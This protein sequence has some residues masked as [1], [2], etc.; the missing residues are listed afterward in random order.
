MNE[1]DVVTSGAFADA[2]RRELHALPFEPRHRGGEIV[3]PQADVVETRLVHLR[4]LL[5]IDRLHQIDLDATD[6][7]DV[8]VDVL[9]L[10]AKRAGLRDAEQIDPQMAERVLART[11]DR[12]LLDAEHLERTA[13]R[14]ALRTSSSVRRPV[15]G[16]LTRIAMLPDGCWLSR[17]S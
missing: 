8:L 6:L 16:A 12:D 9:A 1:A 17:I 10:A 13:H 14:F 15:V 7:E 3:D 2:A 5:G 11:A 4:L